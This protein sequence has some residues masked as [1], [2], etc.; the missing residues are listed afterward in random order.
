MEIRNTYTLFMD[1]DHK[2][3]EVFSLFTDKDY[4]LVKFNLL[5]DEGH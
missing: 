5:I 3:G 2:P 1:E 4:E